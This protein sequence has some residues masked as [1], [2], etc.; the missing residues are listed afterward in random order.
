M[1][2][3]EVIRHFRNPHNF[4]RMRNPDGIGK[5]GNIACGD[6]IH[7]YIRVKGERISDISFQT[8]GCAAAISSSS[9]LTDIAKGKT[10]QQALRITNR[11]VAERLGGLPIHKLH[12]SLLAADALEEA[13]YD[14][15]RRKGMKIPAAL[16]KRHEKVKRVMEALG[17][18]YKEGEK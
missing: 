6:V 4:G 9:V 13:I 11:Q 1:Y 8:Y 16:E 7:L 3:E 12:C 17:E 2:T 18:K 5:I 15:M 14:Y 10:L